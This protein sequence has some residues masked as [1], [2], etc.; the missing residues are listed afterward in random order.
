MQTRPLGSRSTTT[1]VRQTRPYDAKYDPIYTV[2][3]SGGRYPMKTTVRS[4]PAAVVPP[5][6]PHLA[7]EHLGST[8]HKFYKRP[9]IPGNAE[10][11]PGVVLSQVAP[12]K[13]SAEEE[14]EL[15]ASRTIAVQTVFRE[16]EAQTE[17]WNP[18]FVVDPDDDNEVALPFYV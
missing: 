13:Q 4:T 6:L 8:R 18:E 16:S 7:S 12:P 17:T 14:T 1:T 3:T 2:S 5:D 9:D 11:T 10:I 15:P